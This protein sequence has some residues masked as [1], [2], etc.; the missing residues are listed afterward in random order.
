MQ[1][2]GVLM[3]GTAEELTAATSFV[4]L[5]LLHMRWVKV[6]SSRMQYCAGAKQSRNISSGT[7]SS[8]FFL[9]KERNTSIYYCGQTVVTQVFEGTE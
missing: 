2:L 6:L 5:F 3:T 7:K 9:A 8:R 4:I 1:R